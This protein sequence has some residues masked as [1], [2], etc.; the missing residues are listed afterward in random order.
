MST[1]KP[2][3]FHVCTRH[4]V[5]GKASRSDPTGTRHV[6]QLGAP[7]TVCGEHALDWVTHFDR[8]LDVRDVDTCV[9][10]AR[11]IGLRP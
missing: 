4:V 5:W 7:T 2:P 9:A 8:R 1:T 6:R 10:C 11:L 3:T